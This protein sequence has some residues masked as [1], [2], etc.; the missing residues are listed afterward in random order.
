M[1][2]TGSGVLAVAA[3]VSA[4]TG[5]VWLWPKLREV[6]AKVDPTSRDNAV[7]QATGEIGTKVPDW[8]GGIF[9]SSAEKQV[10]EMLK[11]PAGPAP[12]SKPV[13]KPIG[14]VTDR[15]IGTSGVLT[16]SKWRD[17]VR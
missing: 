10:D 15:V 9:K 13:V 14:P 2:L 3:V 11:K 5:V 7:Y 6:A 4:V 1:K 16:D 12:T 8:F 17:Q